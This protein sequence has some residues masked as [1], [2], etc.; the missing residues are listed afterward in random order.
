VNFQETRRAAMSNRIQTRQRGSGLVWRSIE[1][2]LVMGV[3]SDLPQAEKSA[4]RVS[5]KWT[6]AS[7]RVVSF[8]RMVRKLGVAG[9]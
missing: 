8:W 3:G 7:S 6:A 9:A 5:A 1:A 4:S 2:W